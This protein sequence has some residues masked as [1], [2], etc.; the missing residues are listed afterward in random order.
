MEVLKM[1]P[2]FAAVANHLILGII[3]FAFYVVE[4]TEVTRKK[5]SVNGKRS[6]IYRAT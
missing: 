2:E 4:N 5:T 3:C 6:H 1:V